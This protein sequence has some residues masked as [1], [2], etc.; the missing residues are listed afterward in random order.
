LQDQFLVSFTRP[1]GFEEHQ[2][3]VAVI[4]ASLKDGPNTGLKVARQLWTSAS[5]TKVIILIEAGVGPIVVEALRA[6][7]TDSSA[8]RA[9]FLPVPLSATKRNSSARLLIVVD[10]CS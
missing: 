8:Q 4:S 3:D 10:A 9:Y 7:A 6:G 2:P 5:K 1:K